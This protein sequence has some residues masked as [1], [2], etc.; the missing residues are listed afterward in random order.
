MWGSIIPRSLLTLLG[1]Y[2]WSPVGW[3]VE[4][5]DCISAGEEDSPNECPSL[6]MTL[7]YLVLGL[8]GNVEYLF[9]AIALR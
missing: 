8:L 2:L 6:D 5:T 3:A 1:S 4:Y 9:I 7:N